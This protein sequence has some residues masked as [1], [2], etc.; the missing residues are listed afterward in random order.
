M[1]EKE[2][3]ELEYPSIT[4]AKAACA[5]DTEEAK[6]DKQKRKA[7]AMGEELVRISASS[8]VQTN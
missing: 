7:D 6:V 1:V 5:V 4:D 8:I 3:V 2:E